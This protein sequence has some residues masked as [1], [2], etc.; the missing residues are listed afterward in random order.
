MEWDEICA[1]KYFLFSSC[2]ASISKKD[3]IINITL[4]I[5]TIVTFE[6]EFNELGDVRL[7]FGEK[8][9]D[10]AFLGNANLILSL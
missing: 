9:F 7:L 10:G 8:A 5:H 4:I 1:A 6:N 2:L 3:E